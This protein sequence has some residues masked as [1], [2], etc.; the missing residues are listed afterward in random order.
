[1]GRF[2][3]QVFC[4]KDECN[5]L[6]IKSEKIKRKKHCHLK[7]SNNQFIVA[8]CDINSFATVKHWVRD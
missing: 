1:M 7:I 3:I 6:F 2:F 5:T 8:N 4:T